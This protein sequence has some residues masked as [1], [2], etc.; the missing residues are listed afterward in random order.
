MAII[1]RYFPQFIKQ[2][3]RYITVSPC[4]LNYEPYFEMWSKKPT[5]N[6]NGSRVYYSWVG[7]GNITFT[8]ES[9]LSREQMERIGYR[10]LGY[11]IKNNIWD[12]KHNIIDLST[13]EENN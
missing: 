2:K 5:P 4:G 7:S 3:C 1:K 11:Y 13:L 6:S 9:N 10:Y 12:P 8:G